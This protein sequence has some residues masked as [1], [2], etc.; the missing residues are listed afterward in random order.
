MMAERDEDGMLIIS[1]ETEEE[2]AEALDRVR[3]NFRIA[4]EAPEEIVEAFGIQSAG[5]SASSPTTMALPP[6]PTKE[7]AGTEFR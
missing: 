7:A 4:I 5:S 3:G 1:V 6:R 2:L